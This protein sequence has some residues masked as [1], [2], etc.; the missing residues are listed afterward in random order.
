M[1]AETARFEAVGD[2]VRLVAEG[3]SMLGIVRRVDDVRVG[4]VQLAFGPDAIVIERLGS[5]CLCT[6]MC[7]ARAPS[8][9]TI[10]R[11]P[12]RA[13]LARA[14]FQTVLLMGLMTVRWT[15]KLL[16]AACALLGHPAYAQSDTATAS[17]PGAGSSQRQLRP[18]V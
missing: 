16:I 5:R 1:T 15:I 4:E 8:C 13:S 6:L 9:R 2:R 14:N 3:D 7:N 10:L 18:V 17:G 11:S 12:Q